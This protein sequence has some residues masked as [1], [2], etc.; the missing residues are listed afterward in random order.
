MEAFAESVLGLECNG[1]DLGRLALTPAVEDQVGTGAVPVVPGSLDEEASGVRVT[2][3]GN[4]PSTLDV[5]GGSFA[6]HQAE[7][8]GEPSGRVKATD[9]ADLTKDRHGGEGFD[10]TETAQRFDG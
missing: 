9:I 7:V 2:G 4:G 6:G 3:F 8:G 5:T 10:T 1:D